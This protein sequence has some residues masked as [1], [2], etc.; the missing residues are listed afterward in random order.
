VFAT[1]SDSP[2]ARA[3]AS[4]RSAVAPTDAAASALDGAEPPAARA[5]CTAG[6]D[7]SRLARSCVTWAPANC[8]QVRPVAD[9]TSMPIDAHSPTAPCQERN[10]ARPRAAS[11]ETA[12]TASQPAASSL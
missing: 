8:D 7:Q 12:S 3:D 5:V 4:T 6:V 10:P 1:G 11:P 2:A 9:R